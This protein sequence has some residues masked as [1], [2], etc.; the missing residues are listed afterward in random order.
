LGKFVFSARGRICRAMIAAM[1]EAA[2]C[3]E[4]LPE[5]PGRKVSK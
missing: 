3:E 1:I 5:Y 2:K 4:V